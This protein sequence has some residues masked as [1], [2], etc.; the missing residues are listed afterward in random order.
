MSEEELKDW[1]DSSMIAVYRTAIQYHSTDDKENN[2]DKVFR[3]E[4]FYIRIR[5][6]IAERHKLHQL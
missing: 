5:E 6:R 1:I 2:N 4:G 3:E